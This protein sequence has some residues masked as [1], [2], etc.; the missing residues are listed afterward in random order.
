MTVADARRARGPRGRV[1]I[2]HEANAR[3]DH[4]RGGETSGWLALLLCSVGV[5]GLYAQ[6]PVLE[7]SAAPVEL[8]P[9]ISFVDAFVFD[10]GVSEWR[11]RPV[12]RVL[13]AV[14]SRPQ[15]LVWIG[16][17]EEGLVVA[18]EIRGTA[19]SGNAPAL[20]VSLSGPREP[21]FPPIGWGHQF[22]FEVIA[23]ST[24]CAE[25]DGSE[26]DEGGC[27]GWYRRQLEHRRRLPALFERVWRLEVSESGSLSEVG[28]A[29]AF[30]AL[31]SPD[32]LAALAPRGRARALTR[33]IRGTRGVG[34]ELLIPWSAFPLV[35][36]LDLNAVRIDVNWADT[37]SGADADSSRIGEAG[38]APSALTSLFGVAPRPLARPLTHYVTPCRS[39]LTGILLPGDASQRPR[40]ASEHA[41]VYMIPDPSG[42][43]RRLVVLDNHAE[44][45]QYMPGAET[46][47]PQAFVTTFDVLDIGG[48]ARLCTPMLALATEQ[49]RASPDDWTVTR[50]GNPWELYASLRDLEVRRLED[51]NF[52]AL[53]GPR[54]FW[55]YY[56][57][58]QCGACPRVAVEIF[59]IDTK[60]GEIRAAFRD[61]SVVEPGSRDVE[62]EVS[63]DWTEVTLYE[64]ET[65]WDATP[66]ETRWSASRYCQV[67][68]TGAAPTYEVCSEEE[69]V[70][71]PP[72]RLRAR[73]LENFAPGGSEPR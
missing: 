48:G 17:V 12:D 36:A 70:P 7:G 40:S 24:A 23:D 4:W 35:R 73:Y 38:A 33:E 56:G 18:A 43:L 60:T 42:D 67:P 51:G 25:I 13:D 50:E 58:G 45:Y 10:G 19:A 47:S 66:I 20:L 71:E 22:G 5:H 21:E 57:S 1:I 69:D 65:L 64:S 63:A 3:I 72:V 16:Q 29:P 41:V 62:I 27:F 34:F 61:I 49:G 52:L 55:S 26:G 59:H 53:S 46:L 31:P 11:A 6:E 54:V 68:V 2:E 8:G 30:G 28:A 9:P 44:G 39:G 32:R 15:A 14:G 37:A